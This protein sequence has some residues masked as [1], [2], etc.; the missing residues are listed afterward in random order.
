MTTIACAFVVAAVNVS[1]L[2]GDSPLRYIPALGHRHRSDPHP[3]GHPHVGRLAPVDD[4]PP[5]LARRARGQDRVA[6]C[7]GQRGPHGA[8]FRGH[9]GDGLHRGVR[10][11]A[12]FDADGSECPH[13]VLLR[14]AREPLDQHLAG[15]RQHDGDGR[16]GCRPH[17][18]SRRGGR[19]GR[20]GRHRGRRH[21]AAAADPLELRLARGG[22][23]RAHPRDR[24]ASGGAPA[25]PRGRRQ[26]HLERPGSRQS[27][28]GG[29]TRRP[30]DGA[31][32]HADARPACRLP[33]R[34][35]DRRGPPLRHRR[36]DLHRGVVRWRPDRRDAQQRVDPLDRSADRRP[37]MGGAGGR[38]RRRRPDCS[39]PR[40]P[41]P[42]RPPPSWASPPSPSA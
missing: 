3:G 35:G 1:D 27:A 10:G 16:P 28:L 7:R 19:G 38:D 20:R 33:R 34:R 32:H 13:L 24:T 29:A 6:G 17:R 26:L 37:G 9:R 31:R 14:P 8:G 21:R 12:V 11:R 5:P 30:R 42:P 4:V 25:R 36:R 41:S 15:C 40:S 39:R 18:C 22:A 2:T 23:G